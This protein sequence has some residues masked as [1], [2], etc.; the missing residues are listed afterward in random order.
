MGDQPFTSI[1]RRSCH[2]EVSGYDRNPVVDVRDRQGGQL[3]NGTYNSS[4]R[5]VGGIVANAFRNPVT[6]RPLPIRPRNIDAM[7]HYV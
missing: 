2:S 5:T 6:L 7:Q 1:E 4:C 3:M